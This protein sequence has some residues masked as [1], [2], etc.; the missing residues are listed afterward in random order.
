MVYTLE[1][2]QEMEDLS[3]KYY[4]ECFELQTKL[5]HLSDG[6]NDNAR[7]MQFMVLLED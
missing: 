1:N 5:L 7:N 2:L 3:R 4:A 6:M